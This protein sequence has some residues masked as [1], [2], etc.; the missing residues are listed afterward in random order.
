MLANTCIVV[1][2]PARLLKNESLDS[3][4]GSWQSVWLTIA[5]PDVSAL[6]P[7]GK[8][9]PGWSCCKSNVSA[10]TRLFYTFH[11]F[12]AKYLE[13]PHPLICCVTSPR[14]Y[15]QIYSHGVESSIS[16]SLATE[17]F[18][19]SYTL[20]DKTLH[21]MAWRCFLSRLGITNQ[22]NLLWKVQSS[23]W[24]TWFKMAAPFTK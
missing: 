9:L 7:V 5:F 22:Y 12:F 24:C 18:V 13:L 23:L 4:T 11:I 1:A 10:I 2:Q 14:F 17:R 16:F 15:F 3:G 20:I 21:P 6:A 8:Y 19:T